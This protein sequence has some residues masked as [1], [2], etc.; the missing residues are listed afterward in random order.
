MKLKENDIVNIIENVVR[1]VK[2]INESKARYESM[3]RNTLRQMFEESPNFRNRMVSLMNYAIHNPAV[4]ENPKLKRKL[5]ELSNEYQ[6]TNDK[7]ILVLFWYDQF[8]S[9][10]PYMQ[11]NAV[12]FLPGCIKLFGKQELGDATSFSTIGRIAHY[13]VSLPDKG[14]YNS[15]FSK[16]DDDNPEN[17]HSIVNDT[18]EGR[19]AESKRSKEEIM[20]S[21]FEND[22]D[23]DVVLIREFQDARKYGTYTNWCICHDRMN[24][25]QYTND[26]NY[27]TY[28]MLEDGYKDVPR[29]RGENYPYDEYGNSMICVIVFPDGDLAWSTSRWNEGETHGDIS[30]RYKKCP[31][32]LYT[33]KELSQLLGDSFYDA[34]QPMGG[35]YNDDYDY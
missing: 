6:R 12:Y 20:S 25:D 21:D 3:A 28:F 15:Y 24:W 34:F 18:S 19:S 30:K 32:L 29:K 27:T 14:G 33:P 9:S 2:L 35:D 8:R 11:T 26:G 4:E 22:K 1:R 10:I 5:Q 31:D 16:N 7:E 13:L 23:Y 17:Y